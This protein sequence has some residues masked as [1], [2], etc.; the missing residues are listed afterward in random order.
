MNIPPWNRLV[1]LFDQAQDKGHD[2]A[3][4]DAY[5]ALSERDRET[6]TNATLAAQR[7]F[8]EYVAADELDP[9][10]PPADEPEEVEP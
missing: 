7:A 3:F 6:F 1:E 2:K 9:P 5:L 8:M 10:D 4:E